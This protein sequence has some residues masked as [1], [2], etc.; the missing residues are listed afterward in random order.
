M[1]ERLAFDVSRYRQQEGLNL[2]ALAEDLAGWT[3]EAGAG[4][5]EDRVNPFLLQVTGDGRVINPVLGDR[6]VAL[7]YSDGN[8]L[9]TK[10]KQVGLE[11]RESL[12]S[13][14]LGT[15]SIWISPSGGISEYDEGRMVVGVIQEKNGLRVMES[16]GIS[17]H[18]S[19]EDCLQVARDLNKVSIQSY[20]LSNPEEVRNKVFLVREYQG[21]VWEFLKK[22]IPLQKVWE[23]IER[24]EANRAKGEAL[25]DAWEAARRIENSLGQAVTRL[26]YL[27]AGALLEDFMAERGRLVVGGSCGMTNSEAIDLFETGLFTH[28]EMN[29]DGKVSDGSGETGKFVISCPRCGKPIKKVIQAG[30]RCSCGGVYKGC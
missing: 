23:S 11:I 25:E 15:V 18:F 24:G 4:P 13:Q 30:Y 21:S 14:P 9:E 6:D 2:G 5:D 12:L 10:E 3:K 19:P 27:R 29:A 20:E 8:E 16:Y 22:V 1:S 17:N 26:D 28:V 7:G